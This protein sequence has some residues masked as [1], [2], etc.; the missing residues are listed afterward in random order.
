LQLLKSER[1]VVTG[2]SVF[3]EVANASVEYHYQTVD[4]HGNWLQRTLQYQ[5][6]N[7]Q[8]SIVEARSIEYFDHEKAG[9][10]IEQGGTKIPN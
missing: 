7:R 9:A 5:S 8:A 2:D 1:K 6:G 4:R 3:N 10:V